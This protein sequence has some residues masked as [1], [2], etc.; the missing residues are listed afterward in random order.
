MSHVVQAASIAMPRRH[1]RAKTDRIEGETLICALIAYNQRIG[2][3]QKTLIAERGF[4]VGRIK[5]LL[6]TQEIRQYEP[7]NRDRRGR[8]DELRTGDGLLLSKRLKAEICREADRLESLLT[9]IKAVEAERD[10]LIIRKTSAKL[11]K[12]I[13]LLG[14]KGRG[15]NSL[16]YTTPK[17]CFGTSPT[18]AKAHRTQ[19]L[20]LPLAER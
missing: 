7:L 3:K 17:A 14:I 8:L 15:R 13:G 19:A 1:R 10:S 18:D 16:Q 9:Q 20:P 4:H 5:G 12:T 2:R 11:K 6:F